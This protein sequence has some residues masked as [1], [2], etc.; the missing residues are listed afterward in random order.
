[1]SVCVGWLLLV[2]AVVKDRNISGMSFL[3][4]LRTG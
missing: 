3:V 1:M 2:V 4:L